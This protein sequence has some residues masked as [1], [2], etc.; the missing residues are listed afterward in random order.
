LHDSENFL[1]VIYRSLVF[2]IQG[3]LCKNLVPLWI[4]PSSV[5]NP[6]HSG[7]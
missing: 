2:T 4:V 6:R 5:S 1:A 7:L 3:N